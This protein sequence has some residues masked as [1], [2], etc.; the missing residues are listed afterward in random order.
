LFGAAAGLFGA[1]AGLF[2]AAAGLGRPPGDREA[3]AS[4]RRPVHRRQ[5]AFPQPATSMAARASRA[6]NMTH[7]NRD[8]HPASNQRTAVELR[9]MTAADARA[10]GIPRTALYRQFQP[11]LHG[12][13]AHHAV[14]LDLRVR[15]A[16]AALVLPEDAAFSHLTA[17]ELLEL[18]T[19]AGAADRRPLDVTVSPG[20]ERPR[21]AGV[22]GHQRYLRADDV[23][24]IGGLRVTAGARTFIDLAAD[25]DEAYLIVLGDA[26]LARGQETPATLAAK[27]AEAG[28]R[29]GVV[30]ARSAL[31]RLDGRSGSPP[32]SLLRVRIEDAGLPRPEAN[33]D[34]FN[35]WGQWIARPDLLYRLARI[36]IEYE[37]AHHLERRQFSRDIARDQLLTEAGYHV[38][39]VGAR[40]LHPGAT[41]FYE[42]L[43]HL[44]EIRTPRG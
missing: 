22:N 24:A 6:A 25:F 35:S 16:G 10:Q 3:W 9:P 32:E 20:T 19:P 33:V 11:I 17:V 1:G 2:G 7:V 15:C 40:D 8:S 18:P 37:G 21:R 4:D 41:S 5:N 31:G 28:R 13:H 34:V 30:R 43:R 44:L 23:T 29:R 36:A 26:L 27:V 42:A 12:V 14:D 38:V 39:R